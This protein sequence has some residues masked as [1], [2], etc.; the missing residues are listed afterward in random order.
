[1]K[2]IAEIEAAA[3]RSYAKTFAA[4]ELVA[5]STRIDLGGLHHRYHANTARRVLRNEA[6]TLLRSARA[7]DRMTARK[8]WA[9]HRSQ[10]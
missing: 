4:L 6:A 9:R 7:I 3:N 5:A 10:I 2:S 1:M 8:V